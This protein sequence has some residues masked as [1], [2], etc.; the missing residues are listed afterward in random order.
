MELKKSGDQLTFGPLQSKNC[1]IYFLLIYLTIFLLYYRGVL[2]VAWCP[3]DPDLLLSCA[4]DNRILVWNPNSN[5]PGG[6]VVF[7][8][9]TSSQWSFDVQFCPRNPAVISSS[10]FD[11]HVSIYSLMGGSKLAQSTAQNDQ[12]SVDDLEKSAV[13]NLYFWKFFCFCF[14]FFFFEMFFENDSLI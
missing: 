9:P 4:K 13:R 2:S 1:Y 6:E 10:S 5:V 12:V 7:E 11:G 3:Q 8:L 14:C